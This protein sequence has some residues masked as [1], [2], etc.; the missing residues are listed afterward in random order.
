MLSSTTVQPRLNDNRGCLWLIGY[1]YWYGRAIAFFLRAAHVH[2]SF[3]ARSAPQFYERT[4]SAERVMDG[5]TTRDELGEHKEK[6]W[7]RNRK[8]WGI[9]KGGRNQMCAEQEVRVDKTTRDE[10]GQNKRSVW[11]KQKE[12]LKLSVLNKD[13]CSLPF[14]SVGNRWFLACLIASS[15]C[16]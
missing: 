13:F 3:C 16:G 7:W 15:S 4:S 9:E 10:F 14:L 11:T 5:G 2:Y 1:G 6:R 12:G 8:W